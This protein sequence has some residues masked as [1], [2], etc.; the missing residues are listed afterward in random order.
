MNPE[1]TIMVIN[2]LNEFFRNNDLLIAL[3]AL[4]VLSVIGFSFCCL[5]Y[6]KLIFNAIWED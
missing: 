1:Y 4:L 5:L 6:A 3:I 2:W